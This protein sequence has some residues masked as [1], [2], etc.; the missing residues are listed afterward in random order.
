M[1]VWAATMGFTLLL[2]PIPPIHGHLGCDLHR[3]MCRSACSSYRCL[4]GTEMIVWGEDTT[5]TNTGGRY[6]P[7]SDTWAATS[8]EQL[9]GEPL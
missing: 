9:P 2:G 3:A 6:S 7:S 8:T 1:I 5:A 4:T